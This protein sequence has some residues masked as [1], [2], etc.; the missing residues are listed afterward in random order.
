MIGLLL[1]V[2]LLLLVLAIIWYVGIALGLP[3]NVLVVVLLLVVVLC[4]IA[5]AGDDIEID[6]SVIRLLR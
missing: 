2:L 4:V 3:Q 1:A 6:D 5:L